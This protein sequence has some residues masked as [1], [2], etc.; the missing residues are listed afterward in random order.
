M[1]VTYKSKPQTLEANGLHFAKKKICLTCFWKIEVVSS[2]V[3]IR[4]EAE[5]GDNMISVLVRPLQHL[6]MV[7]KLK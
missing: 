1:I 4:V 3:M 7:V 5:E 6:H 2:S